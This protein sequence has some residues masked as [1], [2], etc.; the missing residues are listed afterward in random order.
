MKNNN[1]RKVKNNISYKQRKA[2][3]ELNNDSS[4]IIKEADKGGM[5]VI[6]D[7]LKYEHIVTD[8]LNNVE[9][10][11]K[12]NADF[13][14]ITRKQINESVMHSNLLKEEKEYLQNFKHYP[15]YF[16]GLPKIH[17]SNAINNALMTADT[18]YISVECPENLKL[19]PIVGGPNSATQRLSHLLDILLKPLCK[20]VKSFIRDDID[21]LNHLPKKCSPNS[22]LVTFD[23]VSLYSNIP[24]DLGLEA[25]KYWLNKRENYIPERFTNDFIIRS[26]E[27]IL[28][29]NA[30]D[31][32]GNIYKQCKGTAMGT[33]VAPTYATLVLGYL[34]EKLYNI[35]ENKYDATFADYVRNNFKRFLDDCFIVWESNIMIEEFYTCLNNLHPSIQFTMDTSEMSIPF[36]DI[37]VTI[38]GNEITTDLYYKPTNSHNYLDFYSC[39]PKHTKVNVPFSLASKIVTVVS[40]PAKRKERLMELNDFL[41]KQHY[42]PLVIDNGIRKAEELGAINLRKSNTTSDTDVIPFITTFNPRNVNI[43][44]I[45]KSQEPL[46]MQSDRM[47][48]VISK[49]KIVNSKRQPKSLKSILCKSKFGMNNSV[50]KI[51]KCNT[52]RCGTCNLIIECESYVF[53][54]GF[55]FTFKQNMNCRSS[56]VIYAMI[57]N[58]CNEFYIGQTGNELRK[59]M[60]VHRQQIRDDN[61]RFLN[62]SNHI[63]SCSN[64]NFKI[65][66]IYKV[67]EGN[68][69]SREIKENILINLLKPSLNA[70]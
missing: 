44:S 24:N 14:I 48:A 18:E 34:E 61:L 49:K 47:K 53:K 6:L 38:E 36:L 23:V 8:M 50:Y 22:K 58:N 12:S 31:F 60:T 68:N 29:R 43:F 70:V 21:F 33:K 7:C 51:S 17:K 40:D 13:D 20:H 69:N 56:N 26:L 63:H 27:I 10:Y 37:M 15:S 46:L 67:F 45:F 39:H 11:T 25:I 55:R 1:D 19:R 65:L 28:E 32:N 41:L 2:L 16:Y 4:I 54:N 57:C 62:V 3:E 9:Y 30:F 5:V 59:R 42:P 52:P 64:G 35:L 66:P